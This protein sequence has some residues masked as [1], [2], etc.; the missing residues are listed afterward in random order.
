MPEKPEVLGTYPHADADNFEKA[1]QY[2]LKV[3]GKKKTDAPGAEWFLTTSQ[4]IKLA[5]EAVLG[6]EKPHG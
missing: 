4:E 2:V 3:R 1:I 5:I 6:T